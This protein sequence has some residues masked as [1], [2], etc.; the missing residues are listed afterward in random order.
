MKESALVA[1]IVKALKAR[2][3]FVAKLH[4]PMQRAGL[5][6]LLVVVEGRAVFLEAA[7]ARARRAARRG[8]RSTRGVVRDRCAGDSWEC[9][10]TGSKYDGKTICCAER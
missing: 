2:G 8:G 1:K 9:N 3:L 7:E 10:M 4:G 5:P 6:D